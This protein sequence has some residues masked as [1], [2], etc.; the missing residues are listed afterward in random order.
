MN[1]T[2]STS[3]TGTRPCAP[4]LVCARE[5]AELAR[6]SPSTNRR[7]AGTVTENALRLGST[8]GLRYADS[9]IG[10]PLITIGAP[11][12]AHSTVSPGR[13]IS[14]LIRRS[15][16]CVAPSFASQ[17]AG[18]LKT[19]MSPRRRAIGRGERCV[20]ITRSPG[21]IVFS[22]EPDGIA[23]RPNTNRR[24]PSTTSTGSTHHSRMSR[25]V[26]GAGVGVGSRCRKCAVG[27]GVAG[28]GWGCGSGAAE[29]ADMCGLVLEP[30]RGGAA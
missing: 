19:T 15:L 9:S 27:V 22:I 6:L 20:V 24:R 14:R 8:P 25:S 26:N 18:S 30:V 3:P 12:P 2:P 28:P 13:P 17:L 16:L 1:A 5:S 21:M 11:L 23:Y 10:T 7:P 4:S 29:A